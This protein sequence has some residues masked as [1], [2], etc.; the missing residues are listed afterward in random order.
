MQ[1]AIDNQKSNNM[2]VFSGTLLI[3]SVVLLL[4][5]C[6]SKK[7]GNGESAAEPET[8]NVPDTGYTGI[9][10]YYSR[11]LLIKE[12]T[13]KNGVRDGEMKTFYPGGQLYQTFWYENGL[14]E[15]SAKWYYLEGQVFRS[16]P[17]KH[18]TVDGI[19][20]QYYRNGRIK[21]K[22]CYIK[23][24]R[25]PY[26]EEF[27][28]DGKPIRG[29]PDIAATLSDDYLSKGMVRINFELSDKGTDVKFYRGD[30][31]N[32]VFDTT[33]CIILK[34]EN[35]KAFINLRKTGSEQVDYVGI[36]AEYLS[37]FGNKYLIYKK[38]DLPYKDLK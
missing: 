25:T 26:L 35:G 16:T 10:K 34:T 33:R 15:D 21:A 18:D 2:K 3:V 23:G 37:D 24:L 6:G 29:Y 28:Q 38:I 4:S 9:K 22:L 12:V 14:R 36:I 13:F 31:T 11:N 27:T 8:V 19:Q 17:Y 32:G 20:M 7:T 5:G 30:I 1:K